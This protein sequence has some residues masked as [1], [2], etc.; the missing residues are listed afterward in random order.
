MRSTFYAWE[1]WVSKCTQIWVN[2]RW[3]SNDGSLE[4]KRSS[5][6]A[7]DQARTSIM[8]EQM[9]GKRTVLE[10]GRCK[11]EGWMSVNRVIASPRGWLL[12][13]GK[14]I[15]C[16][17]LAD[18]FL[19]WFLWKLT[20][21]WPWPE[22][23]MECSSSLLVHGNAETD[24]TFWNT[25]RRKGGWDADDERTMGRIR[26]GPIGRSLRLFQTFPP[27]C[28]FIPPLLASTLSLEWSQSA[29]L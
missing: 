1:G 22:W 10:P 29:S 9:G 15:H 3:N 24:S 28:C 17:S 6:R 23:W 5:C 11:R 25:G 4:R 16:L 13:K 20:I 2:G 21:T 19:C 27:I 14:L 18:F 26:I 12:K 8:D 7:R